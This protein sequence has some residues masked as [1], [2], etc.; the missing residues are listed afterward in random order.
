MVTPGPEE[1]PE[2]EEK[3]FCQKILTSKLHERS[4]KNFTNTGN[5]GYKTTKMIVVD[6][7]SMSRVEASTCSK[8]H[9]FETRLFLEKQMKVDNV[10]LRNP[11]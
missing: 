8:Q 4:K 2:V 5:V 7:P 3:V 11:G 6:R 10:V 1:L 9:R